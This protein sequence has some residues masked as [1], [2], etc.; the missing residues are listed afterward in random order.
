MNIDP[1]A[2]TQVFENLLGNAARFA[3][4]KVSVQ[5]ET[6]GKTLSICVADDGKGF[7][8]KALASAAKPY[9][10]GEQTEETYHFG[11]G[12]YICQT[13]CEKHG[14]NLKLANA[15][16]GGASVTAFFTL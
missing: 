11:L 16:N 2:V 13:L 4:T 3:R 9:F 10:S 14:G 15:T 12:L 8:E 6:D 1:S 5:L 7:T